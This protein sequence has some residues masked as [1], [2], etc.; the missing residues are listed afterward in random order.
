MKGKGFRYPAGLVGREVQQLEDMLEI[1][2]LSAAAVYTVWHVR[3]NVVGVPEDPVKVC[4]THA[5]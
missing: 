4:E 5:C 1:G 3:Y 2:H